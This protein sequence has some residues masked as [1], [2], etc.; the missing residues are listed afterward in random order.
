MMSADVS[1]TFEPS[2]IMFTLM[3]DG[4]PG[5][6]LPGLSA[7][8][9]MSFWPTSCSRRPRLSGAR[10][11][12]RVPQSPDHQRA[13]S[14]RSTRTAGEVRDRVSRVGQLVAAGGSLCAAVDDEATHGQDEDGHDRGQG[15]GRTAH[16]EGQDTRPADQVPRADR[17]HVRGIGV[18]S[19]RVG[20]PTSTHGG[21]RATSG[22]MVRR[23][24]S[25]SRASRA[26]TAGRRPSRKRR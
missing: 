14:Q 18:L 22:M 25:R 26:G 5:S 12:R 11:M 3:P 21:E 7:I 4:D 13:S 16:A 1:A 2:R 17:A 10:A 8:R 23:P 6:A 19:G 9:T 15:R 24:P 20:R